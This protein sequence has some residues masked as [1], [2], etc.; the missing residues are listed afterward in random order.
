MS[1][2]KFTVSRLLTPE[3][4]R[5]MLRCNSIF[6][7]GRCRS[8]LGFY[9]HKVDPTWSRL[10]E[11]KNCHSF[12]MILHAQG[13][14]F[15]FEWKLY[16]I[17]WEGA[18]HKIRGIWYSGLDSWMKMIIIMY[19]ILETINKL[20]GEFGINYKYWFCM[21]AQYGLRFKKDSQNR[22]TQLLSDSIFMWFV[23]F[24]RKSSNP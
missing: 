5:L 23:L 22:E 19:E 15:E 8:R 10:K 4:G 6:S 11:I 13:L 1:T 14:G 18:N 16:E 2:Y 7:D 21:L 20:V 12:I 9:I 17:F 3:A 24:L